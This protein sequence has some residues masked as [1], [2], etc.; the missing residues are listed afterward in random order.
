MR[1]F[2]LNRVAIA[3]AVSTLTPSS[4][5][6]DIQAADARTQVLQKSGIEIVNIATPTQTGLSHNKYDKYS[7]NQ[8]GAVLNN[9]LQNGHSQL[10]GEL[11][12]NPHLNQQAA[13]VILNEVVSRQPSNLLGKQEIFGQRADYVLANP[14]GISCDGCGFINTARATLVVGQPTVAQERITGYQ[15]NSD[16]GLT[17]KGQIQNS[18]LDQLDLIAPKVDVSGDIHGAKQINVVMGRNQ[19]QENGQGQISVTQTAQ[20]GKVLDGKIAGSMHAGRIRI[21]SA[22]DRATL[23][24]ENANLQAKDTAVTAGNLTLQGKITKTHHY[25]KSD[26]KEGR[27]VRVYREFDRSNEQYDKT[28]IHSEN[29]VLTGNNQ[30]TITGAELQAKQATLVGGKTHFGTQTTTSVNNT[31]T[32]QSKGLWHRNEKDLNNEQTLH[33]TSVKAEDLKVVARQD[34][35]TGQAVKLDADNLGL[36]GKQGIELEGAVTT[37]QYAAHSDFKRET[38]RLRTGSSSQQS[39]EQH[40][41]ASELSAKKQAI[42]GSDAD[43]HLTGTKATV[44]GDLLVKAKQVTFDSQTSQHQ[45]HL[46]DKQRFWGGLAGSKTVGAARN[47][48]RQHGSDITVANNLRIEADNG[49]SLLGSRVIAKGNGYLVAKQGNLTIDSVTSEQTQSTSQRVGTAFNIL[50]AREQSFTHTLKTNGS[51]IK[52]DSN[53]YLSTDQQLNVRGSEVVAKQLLD[54]AAMSGVSVA[55][56]E[57]FE[58]TRRN[59]AGIIAS[60]KIDE[61]T[62]AFNIDRESI[63]DAL[64]VSALRGKAT[65]VFL[66]MLEGKA[67]ITAKASAKL[68][69]S[70]QNESNKNLTYTAA[71]LAGGNTDINTATLNIS[72]SKVAATD[73][74]LSINATDISTQAQHNQSNQHKNATYAGVSASVKATKDGIS[75]SVSLGVEH[76]NSQSSSTIA[77]GSQLSASQNLSLNANQILHQG[78]QLSAGQNIDQNAADI[79]HNAAVNRQMSDGKNVNVG[80]TVDSGINR[81]KVLNTSITLKGEGGREQTEGYSAQGTKLTA[82]GNISVNAERLLDQGTHYHSA[83]DTNLISKQHDLLAAQNG[84]QSQNVTASANLAISGNSKD[85]NTVNLKV[86]LGGKFQANNSREQQDQLATINANNVRIETTRLNSQ[87]NINAANN[88]VV[89]ASESANFAQANH[90]KAQQGGGFSANLGVGAL[91]IP[92][93][94]A[95]IPSI[96]LS[97]T[98]NG[99]RS[100]SQKGAAATL[101]AKNLTVNASEV[102]LQ[103]TNVNAASASFNADQLNMSALSNH[104]SGTDVTVGVGANLGASASSVGVSGNFAVKHENGQQHAGTHLAVNELTLN[105]N[106][107]NLRGVSAQSENLALNAN[108]IN[109]SAAENRLNK[110][111]VSA[112]LSLGGGL[113]E[114]QWKPSGGSASFGVDVARNRTHTAVT[115]TSENAQLNANNMQLVGSQVNADNIS[116]TVNHLNNQSVVNKVTEVKVNLSASGSGKATAYTPEKWREMAEK[117]WTGGTLAGVKSEIKFGLD[118]NRQQTNAV[119]NVNAQNGW[120]PAAQN[121][122]SVAPEYSSHTAVSGHLSSSIKDMAKR[123]NQDLQNQRFPWINVKR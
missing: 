99:Q 37:N 64:V 106:S 119:A 77:Q 42:L 14:N 55:G 80:I 111:G 66:E 117:D 30:L 60:A 123:A 98:A 23:T 108:T 63:I 19:V 56:A 115:L 96:D 28:T 94:S 46:D 13:N 20:E 102:N 3:I 62:A 48:Q 34:K 39:T 12:R 41:T 107:V 18:E 49:A 24:L 97:L 6:A 1:K 29:L 7:V 112:S 120:T 72:G 27:N 33:R 51:S 31:I 78:S 73:G 5:W 89:S 113:A 68:G 32:N 22:D 86:A 101:A 105:G 84:K 45:Y 82:G 9:A 53:L 52:S 25:S 2:Q 114:G 118:V 121:S 15:V 100:E 26:Q 43:I 57:N 10:A 36:F 50:K 40:Y 122:N 95:A 4:V 88:A 74:N 91:V 67:T 85:F 116:G 110:T 92:A 71:Q 81:S 58:T 79:H 76:S 59:Q 61:L 90:H 47:E 21:H 54:I 11:N 104:N 17:A 103:G 16:N 38:A 75:H 69:I 65:E 70:Y 87:A 109:V 35:I 44:D 8:Q 83:Q 93:A